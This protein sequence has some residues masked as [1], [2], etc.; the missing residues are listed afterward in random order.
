MDNSKQKIPIF[1]DKIIELA[2]IL[3]Q[4][5]D[6]RI[7][8]DPRNFK[9]HF[10]HFS[11]QETVNSLIVYR[12]ILTIDKNREY[13]FSQLCVIARQIYEVFLYFSWINTIKEW[14]LYFQYAFYEDDQI[15]SL[16]E[17]LMSQAHIQSLIS[18]SIK[19]GV[20]SR[21]DY[22]KS[23]IEKRRK[24]NPL[25][26]KYTS[27]HNLFPSKEMIAEILESMGEKN[28]KVVH[29]NYYKLLSLPSHFTPSALTMDMPGKKTKV[30]GDRTM[31]IS[32]MNT[33]L[34][35]KIMREVVTKLVYEKRFKN[36]LTNLEKEYQDL[37]DV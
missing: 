21:I 28:F 31:M 4:E 24:Q 15:T 12:H 19:S 10:L 30:S 2:T 32:L 13:Y 11:L 33:L 5:A 20:K 37:K 9:K 16:Y 7:A 14:E 8:K 1:I 26:R 27:G 3:L 25:L 29:K 22:Y 18:S 6:K 17:S 34:M 36:E 35:L 23:N